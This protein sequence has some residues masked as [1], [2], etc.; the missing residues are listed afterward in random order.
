MRP[1]VIRG[2]TLGELAQQ[3][4][5]LRRILER[6]QRVGKR[7]FGA[8]RG[9][10]QQEQEHGDDAHGRKVYRAR[11][12]LRTSRCFASA[13]CRPPIQRLPCSVTSSSAIPSTQT[14]GDSSHGS[15][16]LNIM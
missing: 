13:P 3:R 9:R 6:V 8:E 4:S 2:R 15:S 5:A 10:E 16:P 11:R 12:Q 7:A 1:R 14:S